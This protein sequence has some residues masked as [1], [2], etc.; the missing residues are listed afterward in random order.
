MPVRLIVWLCV[1]LCANPAWA[2]IY[3]SDGSR[4]DVQAKI[5]GAADGD[6]VTIPAGTFDW[7][8]TVTIPSTKGIILQGAG[9]TSTTITG[10]ANGGNYRMLSVRVATGNSVTRITAIKWDH[11]FTVCSGA[12]GQVWISGNGVDSFRFDN[13][14]LAGIYTR[15]LMVYATDSAAENIP[16]GTEISGLIDNNIIEC[17]LTTDTNCTALDIEMSPNWDGTGGCNTVAC[18]V[19][20]GW[21][22]PFA[23]AFELGSNK[24]IY[25]ED[26]EFRFHGI[27]QNGAGDIYGGAQLV[28]RYNTH[29][30]PSIGWHGQDSGGARGMHWTEVYRNDID[31]GDDANLVHYRS[32]TGVFFDNI[33][34]NAAGLEVAMT[35][36]RSRPETFQAAVGQCDGSSLLDGNT[37]SGLNGGWPCI[38]QPGWLFDENVGAGFTAKQTYFWGN[39]NGGAQVTIDKSEGGDPQMADT[40][41]CNRDYYN[42]NTSFNGAA[43]ENSCTTGGVGIGT[44][45]AR[46]AT[47]TTGVA[48]WATDQG[49][50]NVSGN[51]DGSGLLYKCT[52]TDTWSL[53]YTPYDYP[54]PLQGVSQGGTPQNSG[55][56]VPR[57]II[58]SPGDDD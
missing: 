52:A 58:R 27:S 4:A 23:R 46:P 29:D 2:T 25:I 54:H 48:Y 17:S 22:A 44:L 56:V 14:H 41:Y 36:Y 51:G 28:W 57:R 38:D 35:T 21:G 26:N 5:D 43:T 24:S 18:N 3:A 8:T 31:V 55:S 12:C 10:G 50:W 30:G 11:Q 47:C 6:T 40:H 15:G 37:G 42:E 13:N 9:R 34:I 7:Q 33:Y 39:R 32:G 19:G 45:A 1:V 20:L 49:S 16:T 53:Y